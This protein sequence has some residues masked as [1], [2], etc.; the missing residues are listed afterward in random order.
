MTRGRRATL[1]LRSPSQRCLYAS[2]HVRRLITCDDSDDDPAPPLEHLKSPN[3]IRVLTAIAPVVI[4]VVLDSDL[5]I[6]PPLPRKREVPPVEIGDRITEFAVDRNLRPRPREPAF[7]QH[8][9]KPRLLGC[10]RTSV[11][12]IQNPTRLP[13]ASATWIAIG[14]EADIGHLDVG[15]TGECVDCGD[16]L[17]QRI[18]AG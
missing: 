2:E 10:L 6:L 13:D 9:P 15:R 5:E 12:Q 8:D 16:G 18:P 17:L 3:V 11:G 4:A 14:D 7:E 1:A